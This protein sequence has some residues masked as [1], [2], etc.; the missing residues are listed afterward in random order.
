MVQF[1][2]IYWNKFFQ[3]EQLTAYLQSGIHK[4]IFICHLTYT[5]IKIK[6]ISK[7]VVYPDKWFSFA[8]FIS[9]GRMRDKRRKTRSSG[10]RG[11][12]ISGLLK[13]Y[14]KHII[15]LVI[16]TLLSNGVNL[17][18]PKI[19]SNAIDSYTNHHF[20]IK[21]VVLEFFIAASGI[22]LFS[23]FQSVI[24]TFT[25]EKAAFDLRKKLSDKISRQD[26]SFIQKTNPSKLLTNL[27][28]DMDSVKMFVSQAISTIVSSIFII[29]GV[30]ILLL[31]INTNRDFTQN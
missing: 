16:L 27:T 6:F 14:K 30:S 13:F 20:M 11:G 9:F 18:I 8:Y 24:Q 23:Y 17:I 1:T 5:K 21:T 3:Y 4:I 2:E 12:S 31:T 26:Y 29:L 22:L 28:S 25:S 19:I 10:K 7:F 15:L